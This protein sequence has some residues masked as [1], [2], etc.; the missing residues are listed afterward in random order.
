M[1]EG[2]HEMEEA[3]WPG[4][5]PPGGGETREVGCFDGRDGGLGGSILEGIGGGGVLVSSMY[6]VWVVEWC[7]ANWFS[8]W[9]MVC[10]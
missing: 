8:W 9:L 1:A 3:R 4:G 10:L 6:E 5:V 2:V 7:D